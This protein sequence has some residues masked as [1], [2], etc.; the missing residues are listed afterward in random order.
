MGGGKL[1]CDSDILYSEK[2]MY[3]ILLNKFCRNDFE[4]TEV[5]RWI[6]LKS[7]VYV[8]ELIKK[9]YPELKI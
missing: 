6:E 7:L 9:L 8:F 2:D 3:E 4:R 5:S 1:M